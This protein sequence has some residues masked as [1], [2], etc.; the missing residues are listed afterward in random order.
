[1]NNL[2]NVETLKTNP[3]YSPTHWVDNAPP[4]INADNLN[5]IEIALQLSRKTENDI[6]GE[7]NKTQKNNEAIVENINEVN[8]TINQKIDRLTLS[9]IYNQTT[10]TII[11]DGGRDD[12]VSEN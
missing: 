10:D 3:I 8:T 1:M 5:K 4:A 12:G 2:V 9:T 6:M 11:F 7:V